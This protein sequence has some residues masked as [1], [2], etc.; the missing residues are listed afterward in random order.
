MANSKNKLQ[1][2]ALRRAQAPKRP[3]GLDPAAEPKYI[4]EDIDGFER[5]ERVEHTSEK[6]HPP[7]KE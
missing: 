6:E 1:E 2:E 4:A 7:G 3:A 5:P